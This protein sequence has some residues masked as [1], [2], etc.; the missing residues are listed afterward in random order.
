MPK[1]YHSYPGIY[2]SVVL[3]TNN[4]IELDLKAHGHVAQVLRLKQ[5]DYIIL[6]NDNS[7]SY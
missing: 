5:E 2:T 6:F 1:N 3:N 7:K 4:F